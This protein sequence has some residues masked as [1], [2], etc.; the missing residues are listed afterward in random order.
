M[1]TDAD[2]T[3]LTVEGVGD[4][5]HLLPQKGQLLQVIIDKA[6]FLKK[7]LSLGAFLHLLP[8]QLQVQAVARILNLDAFISHLDHLTFRETPKRT[9]ISTLALFEHLQGAA[10]TEKGEPAE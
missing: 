9:F 8:R 5:D 7:V 1:A 4:L 6:A 3:Y 10:P 2:G